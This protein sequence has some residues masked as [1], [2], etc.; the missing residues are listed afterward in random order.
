MNK[1]YGYVRVSTDEQTSNSQR[2][3][4]I[5]R[6]PTASI[7]A[8]DGIS[9][10]V[11]PRERPAL[12]IL[13]NQLLQEG[14]TLVIYAIDRIGRNARDTLE[15]VEELEKRKITLVSIREGVDLSSAV[16]Q[17]VLGVMASF[18]QM[19]RKL[20]LERQAAGIE[21]AKSRGQKFG[22]PTKIGAKEAGEIVMRRAMGV[23]IATIAKQLNLSRSA[24]YRH[25]EKVDAVAPE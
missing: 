15:L 1:T 2:D 7:L 25:L 12:G 5:A 19:E 24:I 9:G 14:D 22:R 23:P 18:A 10:T 3:A 16:G 17:A 6:F 4:I 20:I 11:P 13:L 8:D 21:A